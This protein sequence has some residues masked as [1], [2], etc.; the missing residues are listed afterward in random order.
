MDQLW[1]PLTNKWM[2]KNVVYTLDHISERMKPRYN[3]DACTAMFIAEIFTI[4]KLWNQPKYSS[5]DKW[6][7]KM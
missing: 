7:K 5:M 6:I 4:A 2:N 1:L 3:R